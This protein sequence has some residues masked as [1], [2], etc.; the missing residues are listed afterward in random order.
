MKILYIVSS[1]PGGRAFGGQLR[2]LYIGRALKQMGPVDLAI[3]SSEAGDTEARRKTADEFP[4]VAALSPE[5]SPNRGLICKLRWALDP[6]FLNLHG[7]AVSS[8][9]RNAITTL[10]DQYD[11]VWVLNSRTPNILGR[12]D[13]PNGHLDIDDIP[14]TYL[15]TAARNEDNIIKRL[16]INVQRMLWRRREMQL[17]RRFTTLSV[18]SEEDRQYLG[19]GQQ[20]HVIPNGFSRPALDQPLPRPHHPPR[21]GF[22]GLYSYAPNL[23]GVRW[24]LRECWPAIRQAIPG[25]RL[26]L[27]GKD[28]DGELRPL[29]RDVDALGWVADSAA[30]IA[31]WSAMIVPVRIGGGTRIKIAEA[32]SRKC[33]AV[34][35]RLGAFGYAV[36]D[37]NQIRLADRPGDFAQACIEL[38]R[39]P[40]Q[41]QEMAER[42]WKEFLGKWTW[43]AI[44]PKVWAA[45]ED[46]LRRSSSNISR[47]RGRGASS[48]S[49]S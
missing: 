19:G 4:V 30:E 45:A 21:I 47:A 1:W 38:L 29:E 37:K 40:V 2:S 23:D 18:C 41:A 39:D 22:I 27:I 17:E 32:F 28:T 14:S 31:T 20:I 13:W 33:P 42:A 9:D 46:C 25:V 49:V 5:L 26:R 35:T 24:F 7:F 48:E 16:K 3:V 8:S 44:S 10:F 6:T 43:E 36:E 11:L 12:W 15:R 34:S